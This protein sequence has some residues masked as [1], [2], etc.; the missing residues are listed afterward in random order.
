M[1]RKTLLLAL[2]GFLTA[3]SGVATACEYIP[4]ETK[5]LDYAYCRYP[6]DA[7]QVVD[8]P[9]GSS[10]DQCVYLLEAFRP[11]ELLAIVRERDGKEEHS[12]NSRHNIGN[13]CY[14]SKRACD[15]ALKAA[16]N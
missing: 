2:A 11:P 16:N 9:E 5:F 8:L 3:F 12:I 1:K 7:I 13:P 6:K 14:L 4:G 15:Q 10:W